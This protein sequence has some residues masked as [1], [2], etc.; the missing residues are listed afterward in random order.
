M[1]LRHGVQNV[2][3]H[4]LQL[5]C[6]QNGSNGQDSDP[7]TGVPAANSDIANLNVASAASVNLP[8][9]IGFGCF[10]E[11]NRTLDEFAKGSDSLSHSHSKK[12]SGCKDRLAS[13]EGLV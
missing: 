11:F 12:A 10:K 9:D 4:C 8:L 7:S 1:P 3:R 6:V 5:I 2:V 13:S